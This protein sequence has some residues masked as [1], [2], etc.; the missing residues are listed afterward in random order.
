MAEQAGFEP[1]VE[2]TVRN[3]A[4]LA[5]N[6]ALFFGAQI[7]ERIKPKSRMVEFSLVEIRRPAK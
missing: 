1:A 2:F 3:H 6:R 5:G 4:F 7:A